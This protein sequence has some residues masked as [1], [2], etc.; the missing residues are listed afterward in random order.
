MLRI[1]LQNALNVLPATESS[2][3]LLCSVICALYTQA[4][5]YTAKN[6]IISKP[7][8]TRGSHIAY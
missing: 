4:L 3:A 7:Q 2:N 6:E 1:Q 8:F 5:D